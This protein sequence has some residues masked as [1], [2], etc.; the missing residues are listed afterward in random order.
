MLPV[1]AKETYPGRQ[2]SSLLTCPPDFHLDRR[3]PVFYGDRHIWKDAGYLVN[4]E[5]MRHSRLARDVLCIS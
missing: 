4:A 3:K 1:L 2:M 5:H